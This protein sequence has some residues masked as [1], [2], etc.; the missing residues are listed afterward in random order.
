MP[1]DVLPLH[2]H[3][4]ELSMVAERMRATLIEVLGQPQGASL[5][6]IPWL[7]D[8]ARSHVD[9]RLPG[10]IFIARQDGSGAHVGHIIVREE[11]D[12]DGRYG[13]VSTI[14]VVPDHRHLG[15][16][17]TLLAAAHGWFEARGLARTATD[18]S[19]TNVPLI[20]LYERHGYEIVFRSEEKKMVRL[21]RN[22]VSPA[23]AAVSCPCGT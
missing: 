4:D 2:P 15:A 23:P 17:T 3:S 13:L 8:R 14:Y 5:Y 6:D 18:T 10:A 11:H 20:R 22:R 9:G 7:L 16:A 1:Y 12:A 21:G 19:Q